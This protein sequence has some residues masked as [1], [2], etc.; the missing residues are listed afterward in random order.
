M[1]TD[2]FLRRCTVH[3]ENFIKYL[4]SEFVSFNYRTQREREYKP[5]NHHTFSKYE[6]RG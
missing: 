1:C 5:T 3:R 4:L 6:H 2:L